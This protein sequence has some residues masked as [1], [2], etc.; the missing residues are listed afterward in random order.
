M[1]EDVPSRALR[2]QARGIFFA[3]PYAV[4]GDGFASANRGVVGQFPPFSPNNV[5]AMFNDNQI[6]FKFVTPS[7]PST[8]PVDAASRGFG[9]IFLDVETA[10]T[11]SIEYFNGLTSLGKFFVQPGPSGN[12]ALE[13]I[14]GTI[15]VPSLSTT[16]SVID[17]D[18]RMREVRFSAIG[19]KYISPI[20]LG[21][22]AQAEM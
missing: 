16:E 15:R 9:A 8:T 22:L 7:D 4:S 13:A 20:N 2:F 12:P 10:N 19:V 5:F 1:A 17:I 21:R 11:S 6:E 3:E 18:V 14:I